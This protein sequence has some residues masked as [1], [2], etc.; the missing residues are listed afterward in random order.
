[1]VPLEVTHT[2]LANEKILARLGEFQS[3]LGRTLLQLMHIYQ[4]NFYEVEGFKHP[5]IH[6]PC[7]VFFL[8][9]REQF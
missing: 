1:M 2:A 8:L 7:A 9:E 4:K 6:D 5:P 3:D